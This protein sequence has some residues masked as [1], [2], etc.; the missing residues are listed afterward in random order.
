MLLGIAALLFGGGC[1]TSLRE[2]WHNGYKVGPNYT[3]P[4]EAVAATWIDATDPRIQSNPVQDCA[5]WMVFQNPTLNALIDTAYR[6]NLDIKIAG[7]RILESRAQRNVAI[8]NLFPQSQTALGTYVHAQLPGDINL[9]GTANALTLGGPLNVAAVGFNASWEADFWGRYRRGVESSTATVE[10]SQD[11]YD[12][13]LVIMLSEVATAY[14]QVRTYQQRL[15]YAR[16][17]VEIQQGSLGI[18]EARFREGA[19]SEL[20]YSQARSILAQTQA[21]IPQ[22]EGGLRVANNRLCV[23]MGIPPSDQASRMMPAPIPK[24]PVAVA[25]GIPAELLRRRPDVRQAERA[26]AAQTAQIG[27]AAADLYPRFALNGF[28]G[29]AGN[30][31]SELFSSKSFTGLIF[32]TVQW[33]VLNYGRILN[34]IRT[35]DARLQGVGLQY[36]K[37]VLT[38]GQ[39]VEDG[40]VQFVQAQQRAHYLGESVAAASR[41][42]ELVDLQFR[43]GAVDFNRVYT[44]Q[45]QLVVEQDSLATTQGDIALQLINVYRAP[46]GGWQT[47]VNGQYRADA[48]MPAAA[49]PASEPDPVLK[50]DSVPVPPPAANGPNRPRRLPRGACKCR[51][52]CCRLAV[53]IQNRCRR[54]RS[55]RDSSACHRR[56]ACSFCHSLRSRASVL[57]TI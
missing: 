40:L 27:I 12:Q 48:P 21:L 31:L 53:R 9:P 49:P 41:S 52:K 16:Q 24:A 20:D 10:G 14:V 34:N 45:S 23:L 18:A 13:A 17:N 29:Y 15:A 30:D 32:P 39:E 36:Q 42:V 46:G 22:L 26:V 56:E 5:W 43:G 1:T 28:L 3:K 47:F 35:Q 7:A 38:A 44:I 6:Q 54:C 51:K 8:G 55:S 11:G 19:A 57:A 4:P 2:W 33:N 50:P 37:V 25:A